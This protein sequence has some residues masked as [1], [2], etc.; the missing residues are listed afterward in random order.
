MDNVPRCRIRTAVPDPGMA[1]PDGFKLA[2]PRLVF[3]T[4]KSRLLAYIDI[5]LRRL[6]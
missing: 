2:T 4:K 3:G 1:P 6:P 5:V